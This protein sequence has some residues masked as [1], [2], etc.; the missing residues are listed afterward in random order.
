MQLIKA[1]LH[2]FL[3]ILILCWTNEG[4][5]QKDP[6]W[7]ILSEVT[8][9]ENHES[10]FGM[11]VPT[12]SQRILDLNGRTI[13]LDGF[14]Y[15]L[16]QTASSSHFVLSSLPISSCFFCGQGGP[17]TV[18]E[19][20]ADEPIRHDLEQISVEGKLLVNESNPTGMIYTLEKVSLIK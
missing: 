6:N 19:I 20:Y 13:T 17:E 3:L 2:I 16:E 7:F 8:F 15:P 5:S 9:E 12:F 10:S 4:Y 14:I 18:V 11:P 1:G